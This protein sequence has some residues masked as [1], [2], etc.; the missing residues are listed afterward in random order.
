MFSLAQDPAGALT[1]AAV[2]C[3]GR[4]YCVKRHPVVHSALVSLRIRR[5]VDPEQR[6]DKAVAP[7]TAEMVIAGDAEIARQEASLR[8]HWGHSKSIEVLKGIAREAGVPEGALDPER[9][10]DQPEAALSTLIIARYRRRAA[11]LFQCV[12]CNT[13]GTALSSVADRVVRRCDDI[14][15]AE[16]CCSVARPME[17]I[18]T[19]VELA[20]YQVRPQSILRASHQRVTHIPPLKS[21]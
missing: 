3:C 9:L 12:H 18:R 1:A 8:Q 17:W 7:C 4:S 11:V 10:G 14:H 16:V 21:V 2:G 15:C 13:I 20:P 6:A 19:A 5:I